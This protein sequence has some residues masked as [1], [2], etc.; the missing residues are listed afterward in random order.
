MSTPSDLTASVV[1][2]VRNSSI[3]ILGDGTIIHPNIRH[4]EEVG[5]D[6]Q[7]LPPGVLARVREVAANVAVLT[8][9]RRLTDRETAGAIHQTAFRAI[10]HHVEALAADRAAT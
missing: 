9:A 10:Q 4:G 5:L 2:F 8:A 6:P 3:I 1:I 7:P